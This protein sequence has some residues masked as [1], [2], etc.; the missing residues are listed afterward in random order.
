MECFLDVWTVPSVFTLQTKLN[1]VRSEGEPNYGTGTKLR[2]TGQSKSF[3]L[4]ILLSLF[5]CFYAIL[6]GFL[7]ICQLLQF[8]VHCNIIEGQILE[9][10]LTTESCVKINK[11]NKSQSSAV[12]TKGISSRRWIDGWNLRGETDHFGLLHKP[13]AA[14]STKVKKQQEMVL[15]SSRRVF[16]GGSGQL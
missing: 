14:T 15:T 7:L 9:G 13:T 16:T 4:Q 2:S 1:I 3:F 5:G 6:M 12:W 10:D 11:I 8:F